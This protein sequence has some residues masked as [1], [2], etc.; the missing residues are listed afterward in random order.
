MYIWGKLYLFLSFLY[1]DIDGHIWTSNTGEINL[2]LNDLILTTEYTFKA[3][4][5][6][7]K[8]VSKSRVYSKMKNSIRENFALFRK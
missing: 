3:T 1:D 6:P 8:R 5:F 4:G 2:T 7:T